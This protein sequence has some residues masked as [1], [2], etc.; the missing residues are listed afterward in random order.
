MGKG[1][2]TLEVGAGRFFPTAVHLP[3][4]AEQPS[5][6]LCVLHPW[7]SQESQ[8]LGVLSLSCKCLSARLAEQVQSRRDGAVLPTKPGAWRRCLMN[9]CLLFPAHS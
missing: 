4:P 1:H 8:D 7:L 6:A 5:C 3:L 9:H 2:G